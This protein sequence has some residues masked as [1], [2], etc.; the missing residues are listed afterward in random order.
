MQDNEFSSN[1]GSQ[2]IWEANPQMEPDIYALE[3]E[4]DAGVPPLAATDAFIRIPPILPSSTPVPSLCDASATTR[5]KTRNLEDSIE[6]SPRSLPLFNRTFSILGD[7]K[8]WRRLAMVELSLLTVTAAFH[9]VCL[10]MHRWG[11]ALTLTLAIFFLIVPIYCLTTSARWGLL[12]HDLQELGSEG[13]TRVGEWA[14]RLGYHDSVKLGLAYFAFLV[15]SFLPAALILKFAVSYDYSDTVDL[16]IVGASASVLFPIILLSTRFADDARQI[17]QKDVLVSL[18]TQ[19][20]IWIQLFGAT[21]VFLSGPLLFVHICPN[22]IDSPWGLALFPTTVLF[23][24]GPYALM[25]G[26]MEL[27]IKTSEKVNRRR[28]DDY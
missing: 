10:Y 11:N 22:W 16:C 3:G 8:Y 15:D 7:G 6:A 21:A 19:F 1:V 20:P 13:R 18:V 5:R 14:K 9:G 24:S 26:R 4:S 2:A 27:I 25:I 28:K 23:L 12:F 17:L